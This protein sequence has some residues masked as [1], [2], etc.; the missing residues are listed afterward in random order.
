[1]R[2]AT[3]RARQRH[4]QHQHSSS[5]P[6]SSP[7]CPH[8][9]LWPPTA[10]KPPTSAAARDR[11]PRVGPGLTAGGLG[12]PCTSP[13][14]TSTASGSRRAAVSALS[15]VALISVCRPRLTS[16]CSRRPAHM[17]PSGSRRS[18]SRSPAGWRPHTGLRRASR[19]SRRR[20]RPTPMPTVCR[21]PP[22]PRLRR[23]LRA[24][25]TAHSSP[26]CS[27]P[28]ATHTHATR[29]SVATSRRSPPAPWWPRQ[30]QRQQR[31]LPP[32]TASGSRPRAI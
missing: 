4:P 7:F 14:T 13:S 9:A 22:L 24:P 5:L 10:T 26:R 27:C 25:G 2:A 18:C 31:H 1:M 17:P 15:V 11:P 12:L 20:S 21:P 30:Q 23:R 3:G 28:P 16:R 8:H 32:W 6:P 19:S 29:A